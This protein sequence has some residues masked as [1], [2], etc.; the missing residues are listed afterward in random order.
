[1][2]RFVDLGQRHRGMSGNVC[3]VVSCSH[4]YLIPDVQTL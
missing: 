1:L 4:T 3:V 2:H